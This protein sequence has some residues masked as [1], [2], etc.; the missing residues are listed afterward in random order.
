M[1]SESGFTAMRVN[2]LVQSL[3]LLPLISSI[4]SPALKLRVQRAS[5][6]PHSRLWPGLRCRSH[7]ETNGMIMNASAMLVSGPVAR[8]SR[9][10]TRS[11]IGTR[12]E[13]RSVLHQ[14]FLPP[15]SHTR[16]RQC[17]NDILR[18]ALLDTKSFGPCQAKTSPPA[19]LHVCHD[20]M[21]E[22]MDKHENPDHD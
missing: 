7:H 1:T 12:L 18:I 15:S 17:G 5:P 9:V 2:A 21:T 16:E 8:S 4:T 6:F 3:M 22:F 13:R 10:A 19:R 11:L 20:E 14:G